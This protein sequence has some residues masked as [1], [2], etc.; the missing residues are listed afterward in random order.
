LKEAKDF[1]K[2]IEVGKITR[3][4]LKEFFD[5]IKQYAKD[6]SEAL[7]SAWET[8]SKKIVNLKNWVVDKVK[9]LV[10]VIKQF[11]NRLVAKFEK[12]KK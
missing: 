2:S 5:S 12:I 3:N 7:Y 4:A 8:I 1:V 10:E 6:A 11:I 9:L